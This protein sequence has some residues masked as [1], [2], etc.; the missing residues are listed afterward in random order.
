MKRIARQN[1]KLPIVLQ[2]VIFAIRDCFPA[3][4]KGFG[5]GRND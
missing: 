1:K 4:V 3:I 2:S 5:D